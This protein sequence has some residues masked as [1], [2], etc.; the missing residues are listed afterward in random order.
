M[1]SGGNRRRREAEKKQREL[2]REARRRQERLDKLA[3]Q[4][5]EQADEQQRS[6]NVLQQ[7]QVDA[8]NAANA[9]ADRLR[10]VQMDRIN[11]LNN[12]TDARKDAVRAETEQ[13][14]RRYRR[15]GNAASASLRAM[16][17][18]QPKAP[19]A[20]QTRRGAK[21]GGARTNSP[22]YSRGSG[23]SRGTNLSI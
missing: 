9:E 4:R 17:Q 7:Q 11:Q 18:K 14:V 1:C 23:S 16:G 6:L 2:D 12:E 15:A 21:K 3:R 19:T 8:A 10:D 22:G 20:Q 5:Q 13:K